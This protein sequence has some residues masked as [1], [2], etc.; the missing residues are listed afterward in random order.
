LRAVKGTEERDESPVDL[1]RHC[2]KS[3]V[4]MSKVLHR[5]YLTWKHPRR[6]IEVT[7]Q[8]TDFFLNKR[9]LAPLRVYKGTEECDVS[10]VDLTRNVTS[11]QLQ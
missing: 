8:M 6:S 5:V 3:G 9:A 7:F 1:S 10:H 11:P 4:A 2:E